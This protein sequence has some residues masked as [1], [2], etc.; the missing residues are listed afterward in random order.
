MLW[1]TN[2]IRKRPRKRSFLVGG[3]HKKILKIQPAGGIIS[4]GNQWFPKREPSFG[5]FDYDANW[6][7]CEV[8]YA[9]GKHSEV[10]QDPSIETSDLVEITESLESI[11]EG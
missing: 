9:D 11:I 7:V 10:H 2:I 6:L 5:G 4:L 3:I 1:W 8:K